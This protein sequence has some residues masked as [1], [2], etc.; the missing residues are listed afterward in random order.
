MLPNQGKEIFFWVHDFYLDKI[1]DAFGLEIKSLK[2]EMH[3][4]FK[5]NLSMWNTQ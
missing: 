3:L 5:E 2:S 1:F 4:L